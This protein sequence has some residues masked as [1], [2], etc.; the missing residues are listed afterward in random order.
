MSVSRVAYRYAQALL[1]LSTEQ[2]SLDKVKADMMQLSTVC[3]E[4]KEFATLLSSPI[5]DSKK[6][7]EISV[8]SSNR[9][10]KRFRL[11]S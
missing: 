11:I 7:T 9:K 8:Q 2:N 6:K 10:L 1:D 3:K 5:V 4:S